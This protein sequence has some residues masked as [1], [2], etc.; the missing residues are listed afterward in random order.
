MSA[1]ELKAMMM[2]LF[3]GG[4]LIFFPTFLFFYQL[5]Q[6]FEYFKCRI[7]IMHFPDSGF[8]K[9]AL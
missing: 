1:L 9:L 4:N 5:A 3:P 8:S 2:P 7:Y 6:Y